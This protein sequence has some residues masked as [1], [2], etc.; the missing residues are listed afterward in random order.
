MA[1]TDENSN[2]EK[3]RALNFL[4]EKF[5]AVGYMRRQNPSKF[6]AKGPDVYK[7][8]WEVRFVARSDE[9]LQA[10]RHAIYI[11]GYTVS[12][13][14]KRQGRDVQPLYGKEIVGEF[15]ALHAAKTK[16]REKE[17][18]KSDELRKAREA[19][20]E[21]RRAA[22]KAKTEAINAERERKKAL[23]EAKRA[24]KAARSKSG[25]PKAGYP[26]G[27]A[28]VHETNR[29]EGDTRQAKGRPGELTPLQLER[30]AQKKAREEAKIAKREAREAL[31][32][33]KRAAREAKKAA[34]AQAHKGKKDK[35]NAAE[36]KSG[37]KE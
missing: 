35:K 16:E 19:L 24:E 10:I 14:F 33:E 29:T 20:R 7:K 2:P 15:K 32:A 34:K 18:K 23:R 36:T 1:L 8:G 3:D 27:G 25:K 5:K 13:T 21:E 37:G 28:D 11:L 26:A 12:K 31:R 30:R 9:E 4:K 6:R 22:R 17:Q